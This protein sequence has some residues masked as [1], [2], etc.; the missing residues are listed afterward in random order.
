[1]NFYACTQSI[2]LFD[3]AKF[4]D[5]CFSVNYCSLKAL[6][7]SFAECGRKFWV[8]QLKPVLL[9]K[10]NGLRSVVWWKFWPRRPLQTHTFFP[11]LGSSRTE[12]S[13]KP[14]TPLQGVR[15]WRTERIPDASEQNRAHI[16]CSLSVELYVPRSSC[17]Y[18]SE[19]K[20]EDGWKIENKS[21]QISPAW[22]ETRM[23]HRR[24]T[25]FT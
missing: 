1:M 19:Q 25:S 13:T 6:H 21:Y 8:R 18:Y 20:T 3:L 16:M 4:Y 22:L 24:N 11:W 17:F 5:F 15:K 10:I 2:S 12:T 7:P 23:V 14:L 9:P